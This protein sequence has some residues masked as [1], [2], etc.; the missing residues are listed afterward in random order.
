MSEKLLEVKSLRK[1]F[2]TH[3]GLLGR[4]GPPVRAVEDVSFTLARGRT[5]GLVGESGCGK[6]TT[7]RLVLRLIEPDAGEIRFEGR[8]LRALSPAEL[9]P[10]R[11]DMQLVFQDPYGSLNPR[12]AIGEII[13]EA[14]IVHGLG[15]RGERHDRIAS[16]LRR[17]GI[18]PELMRRY[19]HE[20][21]GGQRQ[22]IGIARALVL[23]PKLIVADEPVSA[24]DVSIQAQVMN[25]MVEIQQE[26]GLAYLVVA[27]DLAVVEHLSDDV[28][29]MYL[30]RIVELASDRDLYAQPLH[31]YTEHLIAS[32]PTLEPG[33]PR[34]RRPLPGE[35]PSPMA[36]PP[37]CH[38]H[39][40]C[41]KASEICR[42]VAPALDEPVPGH[43]VA[44]HHHPLAAAGAGRIQ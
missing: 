3:Q 44:C 43:W 9:R 18:R 20:F 25:L 10:L 27:H 38:F 7:G 29:V 1:Y 36:P 14:L 39:P 8:D 28:A 34:R 6:S 17:V 32:V 5:L 16:V 4:A 12:L 2:P 35:V 31:P 22:R 23:Q 41:P 11:R 33:A 37:G 40:R 24:L 15:D 19:P 30:G 42:R 26:F 13:A 21:S